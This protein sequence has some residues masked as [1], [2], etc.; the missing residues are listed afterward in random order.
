MELRTVLFLDYQ[1]ARW[2]AYKLFG[3]GGGFDPWELGEA[4]CDKHNQGIVEGLRLRL[5]KAQVY[6]PRKARVR[7]ETV[8][9]WRAKHGSRV[10][11]VWCRHENGQVKDLHTTLSVDLLR[12]ADEAEFEVGII[13]S[14]DRDFRPALRRFAERFEGQDLPRLD[15]AGWARANG[16]GAR[17]LDTHD[18]RISGSSRWH[19]VPLAAHPNPNQERAPDDI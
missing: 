10:T 8:D 2:N 12:M 11:L 15:F 18:I 13:F 5:T 17:L 9:N 14:A 19:R 7:G 16:G 6:L 4:I 3:A 1:S